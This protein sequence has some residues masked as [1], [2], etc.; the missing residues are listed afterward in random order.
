MIG[1]LANGIAD[2]FLSTLY[3]ATTAPVL[4]APAMNTQML[5][6]TAVRELDRLAGRGVRP[7]SGEGFRRAGDGAGRLAEPTRSSPRR[8]RCCGQGGRCGDSG[9]W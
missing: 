5:A 4:I 8:K 7:S 1:K 9:S 2:D 6:H 3:L